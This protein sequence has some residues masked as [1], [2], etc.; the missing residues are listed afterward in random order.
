MFKIGSEY[1]RDEIHAACGGSKQSYLPTKGGTVV[2]ACLTKS[3]NPL[4]PQV[5]LCGQGPVIASA[6]VALAKQTHRIPVFLK[7]A[8]NRWVY[9]G[10]F[11]P[12]EA[13]RSGPKFQQYVAGSGRPLSDVSLVVVLQAA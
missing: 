1:T 11:R 12:V 6:G 3:L 10:L 5:I 4:A 8:T 7:Q 13:F 2:A 9:H